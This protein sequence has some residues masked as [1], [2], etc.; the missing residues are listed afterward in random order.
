MMRSPGET[1][2]TNVVLPPFEQDGLK[3]FG[4]QTTN[5]G[6]VLVEKL[7]LKIDRVGTDQRLAPRAASMKHRRQEIGE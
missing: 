2:G 7:F 4:E 3:I 1:R 5:E 6:D